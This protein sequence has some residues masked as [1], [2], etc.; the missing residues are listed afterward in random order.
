M[1]KNDHYDAIVIGSGPAGHNAATTSASLGARVLLVERESA[2]GGAC[3]Q[4]G[5]IPS[6]T[7]RETASTLCSFS[8]RSGGVY[9]ISQEADLRIESLMTRLHQVVEAHQTTTKRHLGFAGVESVQGQAKFVSENSVSITSNGG[10]QSIVTGGRIFVATGSRPRD[11]AGI[12][13]DHENI[14]NSDSILS[15]TYLPRSLFVLGAGVIAAEYASTF[16]NLG[17]EVVMVDKYD[18]PL[19]FLDND[20][21]EGFCDHFKAAGGRFL[22]NCQVES[23]EWDGFSQVVTKLSNGD[24]IRSDKALIAQ[25]RVAN[26]DNLDLENA[27]LA[28]TERGFIPVDDDFRTE[29]ESV[30]AVGDAVGPPSLASS[31]MHQGR[32]AASHAFAQSGSNR[33]QPL[34]MGI[35]TIP[36]IASVGLTEEQAARS[37][38][39]FTVGKA[40]FRE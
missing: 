9:E 39:K 7:L 25:G 20:L 40:T 6:K 32:L 26:T 15:M 37:G 17:V 18:A 14:L 10:E 23:V 30:Y 21:V 38:E 35:Y 12:A 36:E 28:V 8:R 27:G 11:P 24:T 29:V 22:G 16:A 33:K 5:T 3:V 4:Y 19:G 13:V 34:P 1:M 31:S 2:V